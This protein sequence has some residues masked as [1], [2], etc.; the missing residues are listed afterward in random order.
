[1]TTYHFN[2][3]TMAIAASLAL[4]SNP[5]REL[6]AQAAP[7]VQPVVSAT[8][9]AAA[10]PALKT[11]GSSEFNPVKG[12]ENW[13]YEFDINAFKP[14]RYNILLKA[15]DSAGNVTFGAPLNV[16]IDPNSDL[17][18]I[19]VVNPL[20][21][22]RIGGDLNIV[23]TCVDDDAVDRVELRVDEGEWLVANGRDFWS[24]YLR[25]GELA[26]GYHK[27]TVRGFDPKGRESVN[28]AVGFHLDR[29]KPLHE[30]RNPAFGSLISGKIRLEGAVMDANGL[31]EMRVSMDGAVTWQPVKLATDKPGTT[32]GF[33]IDIDTKRY[34]DGPAVIWFRSVDKVG[35]TGIAAFLAVVDNTKPDLKI[36]KPETGAVL[37]GSFTVVGR[38]YDRIGVKRLSWQY[39]AETG[40]I[41]L[42]PGNPYFT[43]RLELPSGFKA[44]DIKYVF[45]AEDTVGN[46]TVLASTNRADPTLDLPVVTVI[47][48]QPSAVIE[49]KY[50]VTGSVMDDDG[51]T[52]ILW[53]VDQG[54]E[55]ELA[56]NEAFYFELPSG[57]GGKHILS[58]RA[59]DRFGTAGPAVPVPFTG[60]GAAPKIA[61]LNVADP[62]GQRP[63]RLGASLSALEG[64]AA[65]AGT[66]DAPNGIAKIEYSLNGAAPAVLQAGKA[67]SGPVPF[68]VPLPVSYGILKVD[69]VVTD[70]VGKATAGKALVHA[71]NFTRIR[72]EPT[73][74]FVDARIG[75]DGVV[76]VSPGKPLVGA[77]TADD[78]R[79]VD[80]VP[81][82]RL[83]AATFEGRTITVAAVGEGRTDPTRVRVTT[84]KGHVFDSQ[85][86]VFVTDMTPPVLSIV[87]PV[88]GAY[89]HDSLE[90]TGSARDA[91]ALDSLE[92]SLDGST[93]NR[94]DASRGESFAATAKLP[95]TEGPI[96]LTVKA[97]DR[98]GNVSFARS[99]VIRD[100]SPPQAELI[101]PR[102]GDKVGA[103]FTA[104]IRIIEPMARIA[105]VEVKS[106]SG[107][108]ETA[109]SPVVAWV[110]DRNKTRSVSVRIT[111]RAGNAFEKDYAPDLG[112]EDIA[113][114]APVPFAERKTR[115]SWDGTG[116]GI[117][118]AGADATGALAI[119][120]PFADTPEAAR[121][122]AGSALPLSLNGAVT[123]ALS[124]SGV[125][126]DPKKPE[127][128]HG[129]SPESAAAPVALKPVKATSTFDG[130]I[131]LAARPDGPGELWF[132]VKDSGV[133]K[134]AVVPT[135]A[136]F[137][138]PAIGIASPAE[139][140]S[141]S[142][143]V[144]GRVADANGILSVSYAAGTDRGELALNP[145]DPSFSKTFDLG[146]LPPMV[147]IVFTA[148]DGR[149]NTAQ[150]TFKG[151]YDAK[152]D[153]PAVSILYPLPDESVKGLLEVVAYVEDDDGLAQLTATGSGGPVKLEGPGPLYRHSVD[154]GS[155]KKTIP[156]DALDLSGVKGSGS[157]SI[158]R[159]LDAPVVSL[160]GIRRIKGGPDPWV[161]GMTAVLDQA[162]V[163]TG[164]AVVANPP[165]KF[166]Y[167]VGD[168]A[169]QVLAPKASGSD[170]TFELPLPATLPYE[171]TVVRVRV[172]DAFSQATDHM[173]FLYRVA[174]PTD[175]IADDP[176]LYAFD[177]RDDGN[178]VK[179]TKAEGY[180]YF[181]NGRPLKSVALEPASG[182][183]AA[184]FEGDL[185]TV[186][187]SADLVAAGTTVAAT[188]VDGDRYTLGPFSFIVD[189]APP[190]IIVESVRDGDW[191][192][193]AIPLKGTAQDS[194]GIASVEYALDGGAPVAVPVKPSGQGSWVFDASIPLS[195]L[196]DGLHVLVVRALDPAG[197]TGSLTRVVTKDATAPV[198]TLLTPASGDVVNG[199]ITA[200]LSVLDR[201]D[202]VKAEY[203]ADGKTFE[204]LELVT[205]G[206]DEAPVKNDQGKLGL[207]PSAGRRTLF[208]NLVDLSKLEGALAP[209]EYRV[210]D[211]SGNTASLKPFAADPPL[212]VVDSTIDKPTVEIQVPQE[213]E[214]IRTDFVVSGMAF[215]D[216]KVAGI[217]WRT[218]EGGWAKADGITGFSVPFKLLETKDNEHTFEAYAVDVNGVTGEISKRTY[219]VSRE[220]PTAQL[221]G[222][223][224]DVT[225]RGVFGFTGTAADANG[226]A[227]VWV[228]FDNGSTFA[229]AEGAE[230][231]KYSLDSRLVKD[232]T[233]S[234]Y[235]KTVD[236]YGTEG[237]YASLF[238]VDNT[239]PEVVLNKPG[240]GDTLSGVVVIEG[241]AIDGVIVESLTMEL[242]PFQGG[243]PVVQK[244]PS[245]GIFRQAVDLSSF[246]PGWY[247]IRITAVDH[248]KNMSYASRDVMVQ[249]VKDINTAEL[250]F[251]VQGD[252]LTGVFDVDG[253]VRTAE[254]V[255]TAVLYVDGQPADTVK[256][257][258][259]GYFSARFDWTMLEDGEHSF[260]TEVQL[261]SGKLVSETRTVAYRKDG[262]W[263]S[264]KD[265]KT[266]DYVVE[267]PWFEGETGWNA[268]A[269]DKS[270][271][272]AFAA[273]QK[274]MK[275]REARLVEISRD[276]GRTFEKADL[277]GRGRFKFRLQTQ[278]YP[279]GDLRLIVR[280]TMADGSVVVR[281]R[282]LNVDTRLPTVE[283]LKPR[284][285]GLFN[286]TIAVEGVAGDNVG[287][288]EVL[289]QIR[290]GDKAS[291]QLPGFIQG[292]FIDLHF[293][294]STRWESGLGLSFFDDNVKLQV[295]TGQG[296]DVSPTWD[297]I[298]GLPVP[299]AL[300]S[301]FTG[302]VLGAKLLANVAYLPF[303]YFFGPDW[304]FFSM[305]FA[306][307][308]SF[309]Y[310]S[311]QTSFG[312][313]LSPPDGKYMVLSGVVG[314]WEFAKFT[315]ENWTIP[316]SFGLYLEGGLV[317]IP[318][319]VSTSL[320]E[321]IRGTLAAGVR[322]GLF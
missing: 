246:K 41:E 105:K 208:Q 29:S 211:A 218:D 158:N 150:T 139:L 278:D 72:E 159:L 240:D 282:I 179:F 275:T 226:I 238:N 65:I 137:T 156:I 67:A 26:D 13:S 234:L 20:Q 59:V 285:N 96:V 224:L 12:L 85:P 90:I 187:P 138:K 254:G 194:V 133:T 82:S 136:D 248:A 21:S 297:N 239:P 35:S 50:T 198:A 300:S 18:V 256:L 110:V 127:V 122:A 111:D 233:L 125:V 88:F 271:G 102:K 95:Q 290:N 286:E 55:T 16:M 191:L 165:A 30:V 126:P 250:V 135:D 309:T 219:R 228:S 11:G 98:A 57:T 114:A 52:K 60:V 283:V 89:V 3:L 123:L 242:V 25:T 149:G 188:T 260:Y 259:A 64:K 279:N 4:G 212:V 276:D 292:S 223:K 267:R 37:D 231:W 176:G 9:P 141:G 73:V 76:A 243:G 113:A 264:V 308:A 172:T 99:A 302:Y 45:Q 147:Q 71:T 131:K 236:K 318:S 229:K 108:K 62:A 153:A 205:R 162:S 265:F 81:P 319:E 213:M 195:G 277:E 93:W 274:L 161:P 173:S 112:L 100:V 170:W 217:W 252:E 91:V 320:D 225:N 299:D 51:V 14:G 287:L 270:D 269:P 40:D 181:W 190:A 220:E 84:T 321:M 48:P 27:L 197:S 7:D 101:A 128:L 189:D 207:P 209:V 86:L 227:E 33:A 215:D 263:I 295:M 166:E 39:G 305:S 116:A 168:G 257:S 70:G 140:A 185:V 47:S 241:R 145:G 171:R 316:R 244:L 204:P 273:Y 184:S 314:Q 247:N 268:Q 266:G 134:Y 142:F 151:T 106:D 79:S 160:Q 129:T 310:F 183:L 130:Q 296:F 49:G 311:Q 289:I 28:R 255:T 294:G 15:V 143:T 178:T 120:A 144:V 80:L 10:E 46:V 222:P 92:Y 258:P 118:A 280:A 288:R 174:P 19:R 192:R 117:R 261:A 53:K 23:G 301:R 284:E 77:Y 107:W 303:N 177:S 272:K 157:V 307:G 322:I 146:K 312:S 210:T 121:A 44:G 148:T 87:K 83:L 75:G 115:N 58:V 262:P 306:V 5:V 214:V 199:T 43:K 124:L 291:Y 203:S 237:F 304:D 232:G 24:Y 182:S 132:V 164:T 69:L 97:R 193:D 6:A 216:D 281:K 163:L 253:R 61:F 17:P 66:V 78:I 32:G 293:M 201:G 68:S 154:Q 245:S 152:A 8:E 109:A 315:L 206:Y 251:P 74:V 22:M 2:R 103:A 200:V 180:R 202:A 42:V 155:G 196:P 175:G 34:K 313:I 235:V 56:C 1:M 94:L 36:L 38:V 317:F 119:T 249:E 298:L 104:A 63:Y 169:F 186:S 167:A 221:V 230:N 31:A 54:T